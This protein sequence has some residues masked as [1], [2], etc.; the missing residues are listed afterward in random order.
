MDGVFMKKICKR[1]CFCL[2]ISGCIWIYSVAVDRAQLNSGLI[3]LHVVANSDSQADQNVKLRVRDAVV[4]SLSEAM[5]DISDMDEAKAYLRENLPKIEQTAKNCLRTLGYEDSVRA[6]LD[7]EVFDTRHYETFSLPAGVY[8]ALR[9]TIGEGN[10]KNWWCVVF[11]TL[12]IPA[13]SEGFENVAA[14]A[15]F[16]DALTAALQGEEGYE[17]RFY[18]LDLLGKMEGYFAGG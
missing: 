2:C 16:P 6:V 18:L 4:E 10:G 9:I 3:R 1:I 5:E 11:P 15:G 8:D 13:S 7:T 12:C 17:L 14:G